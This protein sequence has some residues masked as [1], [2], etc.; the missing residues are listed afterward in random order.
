MAT[1]RPITTIRPRPS[2]PPPRRTALRL[3]RPAVLTVLTAVVALALA[4][5]LEYVHAST[6]PIVPTPTLLLTERPAVLLLGGLLVWAVLGLLFA[7]SGRLWVALG[8][9]IALATALAVADV[10]KMRLRLEPIFPADLNYLGQPRLLV[11]AVGSRGVL[12]LVALVVA[13]LAAAYGLARLARRGGLTARRHGR[14]RLAARAMCGVLAG[15]LLVGAGLF[16]R[17]GAPLKLL[18]EHAGAE[19]VTWDQVENYATNGFLAGMLDNMPG[20]VMRRPP[21]YNA[22]TMR[23]IAAEYREAALTINATRDPAALADT[24][25]VIVLGETV[26]DPLRMLGTH[27]EED[28][29]PFT[30]RLMSA[31]TSGTILTPAFGGGTANVEFEV[32]TGMA[33]R[34]FEPQ[35][36]TPFQTL[37]PHDDAFPSFVTSLADG[38]DTLA[39]HPFVASFYRRD[40]VYPALGFD[41]RVF[42]DDMVHR[43]QVERN[44]YISDAA[45]YREVVDELR[46]LG[47]PAAGERRDDAEPPAVLGPVRRPHRGHRAVRPGR[48]R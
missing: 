25:I 12:T 40:V 31:T 21:G 9:T 36:R 10:W 14:G 43:D 45:T 16:S 41:R 44:P 27:L 32:L 7:L 47:P 22:A 30:R 33:L 29:L 42:Q 11:D 8:G 18:Y 24:N 48:G 46:A 39:I 28:P 34:N 17:P 5:G 23:Q 4:Y 19:W 26:S 38:R 2:H 37:I 15:A 13:L 3:A 6:H 35:M 1:S 20:P